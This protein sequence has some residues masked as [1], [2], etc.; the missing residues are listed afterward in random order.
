MG[1]CGNFA[2]MEHEGSLSGYLRG[3]I[4]PASSSQIT[5]R[6]LP[7][8]LLDENAL[9]Q[10]VQKEAKRKRMQPPAHPSEFR[11]TK[12]SW[13]ARKRP[14]MAQIVV[15]WG[16]R[17]EEV[18]PSWPRIACDAPVVLIVGAGPA[19]LFAAL[20]CLIQGLRPV[21]VER[22]KDV[23]AR[24]RDL[25]QLNRN[26]V[27]NPHSN[28]C[29]GEGGAG[30]YSDG[31]L[32][33]RSKKRGDMRQALQWLVAHGA[34]PAIQ[35]DA[36][37]HI[38][39]NRL[40]QVVTA[41]RETIENCGGEVRVN[42]QLVDFQT[43]DGALTA[44]VVRELATDKSMTIEA[45]ACILATGHSARDVF[46]LL[47]DRGLTI[48][49][50]PFAMGVRVEHPQGWVD[51]VQYHGEVVEGRLPPASYS[52]VCQ[53]N[54]RGVHSF[55]M[56]PGGIVAPC[57][58]DSE[59][60]V[61]NG[62]SPS[63]RN[64]PYANSGMV[65]QLQ[66]EDWESLGF[67]GPLGGLEFQRHVERMCWEAAGRTQAV[68]AQRLTDFVR[69]RASSTLPTTSYVPGTVSVR[70]DELLPEV[71]A[72]S[73]QEG[74]L[75]FGQKMKGFVHR[76]AVVLAPESRTSSPVRIPRDPD[77]LQHPDLRFMFPTGEGGGY[78]GGILSAAMDGRR[79]AQ[80]VGE[81]LVKSVGRS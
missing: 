8:V 80:A 48:E 81:A 23:R 76:D 13:D 24:R 16:E 34:D 33:T 79:V 9:F 22:G 71:I 29:F 41:I 75:V 49:A 56:C 21:V 3:A 28:Y 32:Y 12:R 31:K 4:M 40:P 20:E 72:K 59:E 38:G 74:L 58:T 30:T 14:V 2:D 27:V 50:K 60:V 1:L 70:L 11:V 53:A 25:A 36:H 18:E 47:H 65:V 68:P 15:A 67:T 62:W 44:G 35:V 19:G 52:L 63:K 45:S 54:G 69:G 7:D 51:S 57:A 73:L 37:P 66:P 10:A 64:N 46:H 39:T 78:A 55:C 61:T 77:T 43:C 5:L 42:T 17:E 26:H 6:V